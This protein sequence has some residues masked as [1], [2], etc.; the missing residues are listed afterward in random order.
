MYVYDMC[1]DACVYGYI[2]RVNEY[3]CMWVYVR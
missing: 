2:V 3:M 1:D